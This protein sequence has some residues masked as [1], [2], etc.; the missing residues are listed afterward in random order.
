[1]LDSDIEAIGS[2]AVLFD[3]LT[4]ATSDAKKS[5]SSGKMQT[6]PFDSPTNGAKKSDDELVTEEELL[7]SSEASAVDLS[8]MPAR[9]GS[10][11]VGIDKLAEA[12]ESGVDL[13]ADSP[14]PIEADEASVVFDE[15][16]EDDSDE[17]VV[18]PPKGKKAA[19]MSDS[20][21]MEGGPLE[22]LDAK[23]EL[24]GRQEEGQASRAGV[25]RCRS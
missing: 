14:E 19:A 13:D 6:I 15:L 17:H 3:E 7:G 24:A 5:V 12:L 21:E 1:M 18:T 11:V 20:T 23:D 9:K 2:S 16:L 4:E 8:D 22:G 10:S 25:R